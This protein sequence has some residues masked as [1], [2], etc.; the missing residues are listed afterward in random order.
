[1]KTKLFFSFLLFPT[2]RSGSSLRSTFILVLLSFVFF[3]LSSQVPQGFNYQA[4]AR[5]ASGNPI[6]GGTLD[7][8][9]GIQADT[10]ASPVILWE[11]VHTGVKTNAFGLFAVVLGNGTK[12]NG[13]AAT[14]ADVNWSVTPL[15][16]KTQIYYLSDWKYMGSSKIWSVP[17]ALR[18]KDSE[19]KQTLSIAG[20][21]ISISGGNTIS[22][23]SGSNL[24]QTDG[25]NIYRQTGNVGFGTT[26]P[27]K[28][29]ETGGISP[30][31]YFNGTT[32][33]LLE[34]NMQGVAPPSFTTR[35]N[36]T[37]IALYPGVSATTAEYALGIDASTFWLSVP[38]NTGTFKFYSGTSEIMR[39]MGTGNVG[40]GTA[41]PSSR[42][43]VKG[44]TRSATTNGATAASGQFQAWTDNSAQ[45]LRA[46][47]SFYPT[48][49]ATPTDNV[50]RR[51][52]DI[53]G[54]FGGGSWGKE[55][56]SFN[57]GSN[58]AANDAQNLTSE[59]MR[60]TSGG[61]IGI[62]TTNPTSKMVIQ[63]SATW[64]DATPL[65]EV[66]N[67]SGMTVFAVYNNGVRIYVE[68]DAPYKGLKGGFAIGGFNPAK[69]G[70]TNDYMW[71][72]P[73]SVRVYVDNTVTKGQ[74][75]GFAIGS[76]NPSKGT[77]PVTLTHLTDINYLIGHEAGAA[78]TNGKYN[79][80]FGYQ[81]GKNT[82]GGTPSGNSYP[83][84]A[85]VFI[86]YQ[87]GFS[88]TTG[89][90]NV[91]LGYQ[92][93][94]DNIDGYFNTFIGNASGANNTT[95]MKN[96]FVGNES[97]EA[98]MIG[99][100]NTFYG[101]NSGIMTYADDNTFVGADCGFNNTTGVQN[102][103]LGSHAG[104]YFRGSYNT[105]LGTYAGR[106]YGTIRTGTNNIFIG[107][108]A[109]YSSGSVSNKLYIDPTSTSAPLI[110]GDFTAG[111]EVVRINGNLEYT[112]TIADVSDARL[113]KNIVLI[114][115]A[116]DKITSLRGVFFDWN[117]DE[118]PG[119]VLENRHQVGVIAQEVEKV[120]P[121]IVI[122]SKE[123]YMMVD[124]SKL[125]PVLIEAVKDQ[126]HQIELAKQE[127]LKLKNEV[128]GLREEID[129]I[130]AVM[131]RTGLK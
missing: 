124:Y 114:P 103:F 100:Y 120:L 94:Q 55:F 42:L 51:A 119:F 4:I 118:N 117:L 3:N 58:G 127:N 13:S 89:Y 29:I 52:A 49:E 77:I 112:G 70:Y 69:G 44:V 41:A 105:F 87:T 79:T 9:L 23:P 62:G 75:G 88:N 110:Y 34:Y 19:T 18:A 86:G 22:L 10:S 21:N 102:A 76:F 74:K 63:P 108:S 36:G 90:K 95:G 71:V 27:T 56:L 98:N 1:M 14:F 5:D 39:I 20:L 91:F 17:Y 48:F 47:Y 59:K 12:T 130:K 46:V 2:L 128:Q 96:T 101:Y 123:G 131:T 16:L 122:M 116:I 78:I 113:K 80:Y 92:A 64:D 125:T 24:W 84:W 129:Q 68:D 115:D 107:A 35:S 53:V 57:V 97:G 40:I 111:S 66:K 11:E 25:T 30:S 15:F 26:S 33:N 37:K 54:G 72:T 28:K 109:G 60:I 31:V 67:K 6:V 73:D 93:G 32:S 82:T 104:E 8:K 81:A 85:N 121:E 50:G 99:S 83:G 45:G 126:Q 106:N 61:M 38:N 7:V 65:F 43:D